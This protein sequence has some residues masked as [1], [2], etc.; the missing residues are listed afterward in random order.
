MSRGQDAPFGVRLRRLRQATGLTQE[1]LAGRAGLSAKN[2][3]DLE[4]GERRRPYPHTVRALADVLELPEHERAALFAAVPRRDATVPNMP[5]AGFP[6][7]ALPSP[8]TPLVGRELELTEISGILGSS[9]VRLLT[10]T[11]IG[12]VGKTRLSLAVARVALAENRFP[13]GVAYVTLAPL[14][15]PALVFSAIARSLGV[16]EEQGQGVADALRVYLHERQ[17]L[18]VLDNFE[19]LLEAAQEVAG[20]IESCPGLVVLTTSRAPLRVRGEQEYPVPPLA[21]PSS[22]HNPTEEEVLSTSSGRLF[23]ERA[24]AASPSFVLTAENTG[25]VAAICWRLAGLPLALELAA[26]RL[27]LLG[28]ASL[29]AR[30]D[31]ALS[32]GWSRDLPERQRTMGATLDWSHGLLCESERTLFRRLSIFYDGFALGAAEAVGAADDLGTKDVLALLGRL[33]DQSLVA[34]QRDA[35]GGEVRYGMLE[36]VRQYAREKLEGSGEARTVGRRHASFFLA[37]AERAQPEL[38]GARQVEWLDRLEQENGNLMTA[39]SWA[40]DTGEAETGARMGWALWLYWMIR[41]YQREGRRWMEALLALDL[42]PA[43]RARVLVA[44]ASLAYGYG[45]YEWCERYSEEGLE[46]SR[47]VGD[48]LG[49]AWAQFG[50]GVAAM[51]RSDHEAATPHLRESL[52]SFREV[53]EDFGVAR[54]TICLGMVAL[55]R[56]DVSRAIDTFGEALTVARRIGDKTGACITLYNLA[57]VALSHGDHCQAATHFEEGIALSGQVSDRANV[58]YC[59]EGLATIAGEQG[60]AERSARLFGAAE[61]MRE[62]LGAPVYTYYEPDPFLHERAM[63]GARSQLGDTAFEGAR[64]R[65]RAMTFEQAVAYALLNDEASAG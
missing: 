11:G 18:L 53:G 65:G 48:E 50:L 46:L 17:T 40:L 55:M 20:L 61:G 37:L 57:Q 64:E 38:M 16:G 25:A 28:P 26:A 19:H 13:D 43:L 24:K 58:A 8:P 45:D 32:T 49:I 4:R 6:G 14:R 5:V 39:V 15:D 35:E 22:I 34:V 52:R 1:E 23:V 41:G 59:L 27:R 21:L 29:L 33:V 60:K 51:S 30:L 31:Q 44:V 3:S 56:D 9:E 62:V 42:W 7:T 54:A 12:G 36:P 47:Q 63:T 2:I 10:L